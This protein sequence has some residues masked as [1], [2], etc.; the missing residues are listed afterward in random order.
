MHKHVENVE[1]PSRWRETANV[2][3]AQISEAIKGAHE[4]LQKDNSSSFWFSPSKEPPYLLKITWMPDLCMEPSTFPTLVD[5]SQELHITMSTDIW[6]IFVGNHHR[7]ITTVLNGALKRAH[8]DEVCRAY[9]GM[10]DKQ[11]GYIKTNVWKPD[12]MSVK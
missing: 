5:S 11:L 12:T 4:R 7:F 9:I 6:S 10:H 2:L 1:Y 3:I 8:L